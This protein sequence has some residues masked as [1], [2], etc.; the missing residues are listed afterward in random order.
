MSFVSFVFPPLPVAKIAQ[1]ILGGTRATNLDQQPADSQAKGGFLFYLAGFTFLWLLFI[2]LAICTV[3]DVAFSSMALSAYFMFGTTLGFLRVSTR[4][5]LGIT[6]DM[7][8]DM[9]ACNFWMPFAVG[10][11]YAED[12]NALAPPKEA[13]KGQVIGAER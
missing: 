2:V 12:L 8:T 5:K 3:V 9:V 11:M 13:A 4:V 6:G 7:I 10:Q 1:Q